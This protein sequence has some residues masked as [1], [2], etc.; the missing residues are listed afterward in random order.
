MFAPVYH[1]AMRYAGPVRKELAV[2]T[3][4]NILGPLTNPAKAQTQL[5]GVYDEALLDPMA[6]VLISLGVTRGLVVHGRAGEDE[7]SITG[8]TDAVL[9]ENGKKSRLEIRPEDFSFQTAPV[10]AVQGEDARENAR[11][12]EAVFRGEKSPRRDI[13]AMNAGAALFLAGKADTIEEGVRLAESVIDSGNALKKLEE[14]REVSSRKK[15]QT[16]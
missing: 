8:P 16:A 15:D 14:I 7:I 13:V 1:S 5:L 11:I 3:V 12:I 10:E 2:P 6:D 9:I 4:F